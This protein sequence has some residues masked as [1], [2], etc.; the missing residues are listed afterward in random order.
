ME[1]A[2]AAGSARAGGSWCWTL[3]TCVA[4]GFF[5]VSARRLVFLTGTGSFFVD[6]KPSCNDTCNR[7]PVN[8]TG[9]FH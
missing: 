5:G 6:V 7:E 1:W 2:A 8:E 4:G 9:R 3:C